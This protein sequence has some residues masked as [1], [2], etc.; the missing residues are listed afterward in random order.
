MEPSIE[1]DPDLYDFVPS[2]S[3]CT[4]CFSLAESPETLFATFQG[5]QKADNWF[6]ALPPPPNLTFELT[7]NTGCDWRF[8]DLTWDVKWD[9]TPAN[10]VIHLRYNPSGQFAF[11]KTS[12]GN[13]HFSEDSGLTTPVANIYYAGSVV[14]NNMLESGT[15]W[16][17]DVMDLI[18]L[19]PGPD[20]LA[21]PNPVDATESVFGFYDA[22]D[23]TNVLVRFDTP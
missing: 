16:I 5:I 22:T 11:F 6:G 17:P 9:N 7:H 13:C 10:Q 18:N 12:I 19:V 14:I 20:V 15:A 1:T 2:G 3:G 21:N 8:N 4:T 23:A